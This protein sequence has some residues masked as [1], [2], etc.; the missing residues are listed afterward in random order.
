MTTVA[1]PPR[2]WH[3]LHIGLDRSR[4]QADRYLT[5]RLAPALAEPTASGAVADWFFIRYGEGGHHLRLRLR[6]SEP[7][8]V[9]ELA[10]RLAEG[11]DSDRGEGVSR[12]AYQPET[13]RYGG[14]NCLPV[15]EDVFCAASRLAIDLLAAGSGQAER[16]AAGL[17]LTLATAA[18]LDLDPQT[19]LRWLRV[20][21]YS[22]RWHPGVSG[23]PA[24]LLLRSA[25]DAAPARAAAIGRRRQAI[26]AGTVPADSPVSR[27]L[28]V[29]REAR[30]HLE[31]GGPLPWL[32]VWGSQLHMLC[33]RLGLLPDEERWMSWFLVECALRPDTAAVDGDPPFFDP[34][35]HAADRRFLTAGRYQADDMAARQPRDV[36]RVRPLV[37][38]NPFGEKETRLPAPN[39]PT[40]AFTDALAG[41][42]SERD[43]IGPLD[44][45]ALATLLWTA[46]SPLQE[47]PVIRWGPRSDEVWQRRPYP[48]AGAQ[49]TVRARLIAR[50]V[51][52]LA[53]GLYAVDECR[54]CLTRITDAPSSTD[55][56]AASMWFRA[57]PPFTGRVDSRAVPA[58]LALWLDLANL[59]ARY[60]LRALR[61][62]LLEA[63]HVAQNLALAATA[64]GLVTATIGGFYDDVAAE[65]LMLDGL[66]EIPVYLM[67]VGE[68]ISN[69]ADPSGTP[70][71]RQWTAGGQS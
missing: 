13:L 44:S 63:G 34:S 31:T 2:V 26:R 67:P 69:P 21:A 58:V 29:V 45:A 50:D 39:R 36:A 25:T 18:A 15:A 48:S 32:G 70:D 27:W 8:V 60:G 17:D 19:E 7:G 42:T 6:D 51:S 1:A 43:Q 3:S 24:D 20:N 14:P 9:A 61:F 10:D 47:A 5:E 22:W 71:R 59:R 64:A 41:R 57:T 35:P 52:G 23:T 66:D 4:A 53:A 65:L 40:M 46:L 55:L 56:T 68:R 49:Y 38:L 28:R 30:A 16:L 11:L 37:A 33:N 54:Q 62:G 12:H